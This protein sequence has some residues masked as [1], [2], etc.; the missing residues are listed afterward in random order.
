MS[1]SMGTIRVARVEDMTTGDA[2]ELER[3]NCQ[4]GA[5]RAIGARRGFYAVAAELAAAKNEARTIARRYS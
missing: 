3:L 2:L 5:L 1:I 4:I